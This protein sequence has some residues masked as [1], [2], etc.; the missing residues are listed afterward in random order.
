M[1]GVGV[2]SSILVR[3]K[4]LIRSKTCYNR[5]PSGTTL[6]GS[7]SLSTMYPTRLRTRLLSNGN[8]CPL[9]NISSRVGNVLDWVEL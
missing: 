5:D 3:V 8:A 7:R 2:I 4:F 9:E 1:L 6:N